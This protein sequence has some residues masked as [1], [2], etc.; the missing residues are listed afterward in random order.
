MAEVHNHSH[1]ADLR[2]RITLLPLPPFV[3]NRTP[4]LDAKP[5]TLSLQ[6]SPA[7]L[8]LLS[9]HVEEDTPEQPRIPHKL[10]T[11]EA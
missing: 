4:S 9:L 10:E 1:N 6:T 7:R 2:G 11:E 5:A 8:P 3:G